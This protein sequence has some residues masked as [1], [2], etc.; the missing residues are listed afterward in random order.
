MPSREQIAVLKAN[1]QCPTC[2]RSHTPS[3]Y[4]KCNRCREYTKAYNK[5]QRQEA[6]DT[7]M[8]TDCYKNKSIDNLLCESCSEKRAIFMFNRTKFVHAALGAKCMSCGEDTPKYLTIAHLNGDGAA[9]KRKHGGGLGVLRYLYRFIK[10]GNT[11]PEGYGL[12]C[13]NCNCSQLRK[14]D[15]WK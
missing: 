6:I 10:E 12:E 15:L 4:L 3:P 8:C 5:R 1:S 13:F 11:I 7:G 9:D 14:G 2:T